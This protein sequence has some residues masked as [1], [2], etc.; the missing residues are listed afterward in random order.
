MRNYR[1]KLNQAVGKLDGLKV[2][3]EGKIE[4][5]GGCKITMESVLEAQSVIQLVAQKTQEKLKFHIESIVTMALEA[6]FEEPYRFEVDFEIK[7]GR[8]VAECWFVRN[9]EKVNPMDATGGGAVDIASMALRVVFW[10]LLYQTK[11]IRPLLVLD[12]PF[13]FVSRD[14]QTKA[15]EMVK[16]IASRLGIQFIVVTHT[17]DLIDVADRVYEVKLKDGKSGIRR[18]E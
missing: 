1:D 2:Q 6:V 3:L 7:G 4:K 13:R 17:K 10:S 8:T 18:I 5:L 9:G 16:E 11:K 14:L 15:G 12:E